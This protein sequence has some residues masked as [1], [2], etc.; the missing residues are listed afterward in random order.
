MGMVRQSHFSFWLILILLS[1]TSLTASAAHRAMLFNQNAMD[2][3]LEMW[4]DFVEATNNQ[5][6]G[7]DT[8]GERALILTSPLREH[9]GQLLREQPTPAQ[10]GDGFKILQPLPPGLIPLIRS[11]PFIICY[12]RMA[13]CRYDL[14]IVMTL[15]DRP[16]PLSLPLECMNTVV[17]CGTPSRQTPGCGC[18]V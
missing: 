14:V 18:M 10:F 17:R 7:L 11:A 1:F 3:V 16:F 2:K 15:R 4:P 13:V 8:P 9:F 6:R 5:G 12:V